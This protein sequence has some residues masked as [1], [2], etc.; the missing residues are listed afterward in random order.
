[1]N[2]STIRSML[3]AILASSLFIA[4][5][6]E[7]DS[8][9]VQSLPSGSVLTVQQLRDLFQGNEIRFDSS[10][11]VYGVVTAD[12]S[13]GNLYKSIYMQDH[14]AAINLRLVNSGGLYQGDSIRIY[15]PGTILSS[16]N[17][18]LQLDSVDVDNNVV[19]QEVNVPKE[20]E[21]VTIP[22]INSTKQAK[23]IRL[24]NV[25]FAVSEIGQTYSDPIN[26]STVNRTLEDCDGNQ[27]LVRTSG[28]ANFAGENI[29]LYNGDFVA[30]V[31]EFQGTMQLYIR[32]INEI[33]LTGARCDS[34]S[35][36]VCP[37]AASVNQPFDNVVDNVD[38]DEMCWRNVATVGSRVWRGDEFQGD[39]R[40]QATA[41]NSS[42][43]TNTMWLISPNMQF[44]AGMELSFSTQMA[45]YTHDPF[46]VFISTDFNGFNVT[47]ATWDPISA[48]EASVTDPENTWIPSGAI[49]LDGYLPMGYTGNFYIGFRYTGSGPNNQTTSYRIDNIIIQ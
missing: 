25:E 1:M 43:A 23:L 16:Y 24:E 12:E 28:Y 2:T 32:N 19:K 15:L 3:L 34:M 26:Q 6:K 33:Q 17:G 38:F 41:Y 42:D 37:P 9:P 22:Q 11:S 45:F 40:L 30:V 49:N 46:D 7:Y 14:T 18:M 35:V 29:P 20:P 48:T 36:T 8:P 31:S 47:S 5:E 44:T 4:C 13:S 10:M 21:L 27:V 39:L